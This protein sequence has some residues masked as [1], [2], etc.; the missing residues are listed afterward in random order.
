MISCKEP[1]NPGVREAGKL[2]L[3]K[4]VK[5]DLNCFHLNCC[6]MRW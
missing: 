5:G 2:R 4:R 1:D 3:K 6:S